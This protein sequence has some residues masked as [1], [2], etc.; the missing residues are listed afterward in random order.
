MKK[1]ILFTIIVSMFSPLKL[2]WTQNKE[3]E[4]TP[5]TTMEEIIKKTMELKERGEWPPRK[6]VKSLEKVDIRNVEVKGNLRLEEKVKGDVVKEE[7]PLELTVSDYRMEYGRLRD[8]KGELRMRETTLT[9][10][11]LQGKGTKVNRSFVFWRKDGSS[12]ASSFKVVLSN[13]GNDYLTFVR[14]FS[15][16]LKDIG[17]MISDRTVE[18]HRFLSK[19]VSSIP[20]RIPLRGGGDWGRDAHIAIAKVRDITELD[21][22]RLKVR[23]ADANEILHTFIGEEQ[24]LEGWKWNWYEWTYQ[25]EED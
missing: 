9:C 4:I 2:C 12:F 8:D 24:H 7:V 25:P 19:D 22:K 16:I 18:F 20:I 13:D 10:Y 15:V 6:F 3:A 14:G 5:V 23:I 17:S 11:E 1:I 21:E